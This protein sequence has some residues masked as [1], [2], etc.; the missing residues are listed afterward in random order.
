MALVKCALQLRAESRKRAG[1][2]H[3]HSVL[4]IDTD[5]LYDNSERSRNAM[6]IAQGQNLDLIRQEPSFE[7]VLL[8]LHD[9]H[10]QVRPPN[11]A[12]ALAQLRAIWREYRKPV[13][14]QQLSTHFGL[15]DLHR[16]ADI[17][18]EICRLLETLGLRQPR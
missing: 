16:L 14:R 4:L 2:G 8:R 5:R 10:E 1:E 13:N 18:G 6:K 12:T 3:R 11:P 15:A 7:A 9:G 17:D